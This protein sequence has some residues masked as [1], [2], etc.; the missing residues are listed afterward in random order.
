M[1][2]KALRFKSGGL[3]RSTGTPRSRR[4]P[5]AKHRA[6]RAGAYGP[7]AKRQEIF[8]ENVLRRRGRGR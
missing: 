2:R 7:K 3:H 8:Y 6:A 5:A 1:A 4:I